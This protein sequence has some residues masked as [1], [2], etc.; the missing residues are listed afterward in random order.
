VHCQHT[1]LPDQDLNGVKEVAELFKRLA[2][3][4]NKRTSKIEENKLSVNW[5]LYMYMYKLYRK[6]WVICNV[7]QRK[8][9]P[10]DMT[11]KSSTSITRGM[12]V[13]KI[14]TQILREVRQQTTS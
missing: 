12:G 9:E 4:L 3:E 10:T 1:L 14:L 13:T 5:A 2:T 8:L 7:I 11:E 6:Y